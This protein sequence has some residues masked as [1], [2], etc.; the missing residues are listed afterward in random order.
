[1]SAAASSE[2]PNASMNQMN[3]QDVASGMLGCAKASATM[4]M[5]AALECPD[6]ELRNLLVQ[7]AKN[8]ADQAYETWQFMNGMGY[9]QVP[10]LQD[11]TAKTMMNHYQPA[12][13]ANQQNP[14]MFQ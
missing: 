6:P 5:H 9:Y 2:R 7:G 10:T 4:R 8:C 3:D 14:Q 11:M 13:T 1:M 12:G